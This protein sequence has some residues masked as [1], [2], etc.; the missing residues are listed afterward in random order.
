MSRRVWEHDID[1]LA[2]RHSVQSDADGPVTATFPT[3]M[4]RRLNV[5]KGRGASVHRLAG[6]RGDQSLEWLLGTACEGRQMA[7]T[8]HHIALPYRSA[9]P[10]KIATLSRDRKAWRADGKSRFRVRQTRSL[11]RTTRF[12]GRETRFRYGQ[13][14]FLTRDM[15]FMTRQTRFQV[16]QTRF[17]PRQVRFSFCTTRVGGRLFARRS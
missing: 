2:I 10:G 11:T 14:R 4:E 5:W 6:F 8:R 3:A 7:D 16:R 13:M 17:L 9:K 1:R 15:R 12:A